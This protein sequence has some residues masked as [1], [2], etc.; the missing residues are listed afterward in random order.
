ML[1]FIGGIVMA[2]GGS[3]PGV[4]GGT[5]AFLMGFFDEMIRSVNAFVSK[6]ISKEER[7]RAFFF[8][9][10]LGIGYVIGLAAATF[11]ITEFF[12]E[13]IY[14]VCS[15]FIGITL[16]SLP[17][18]IYEEWQTLKNKALQ[19]LWIIPGAAIIVGITLLSQSGLFDT[20][21]NA[22]QIALAFPAGILSACAMIMPGISGAA[23]FFIFGLYTPIFDSLR[24]IVQFDFSVLPLLLSLGAGVVI[25]LLGVVK[26]V[27]WLLDNKRPATIYA[28]LGMMVGSLYSIWIGPSTV[29]VTPKYEILSFDTFNWL[30]F[31]IGALL[32]AIFEG[33]K[34]FFTAR[35]EKKKNVK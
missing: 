23:I 12:K 22:A 26:G 35:A 34:L 9:L 24:A 13:H 32:I 2:L 15:L 28:I 14:P 33:L 18:V 27:R 11:L 16:F 19:A 7:K 5:I 21:S 31:F 3:A 1:E 10:R 20:S 6:G 25:G 29:D 30:F 4:S 17:L 8:I